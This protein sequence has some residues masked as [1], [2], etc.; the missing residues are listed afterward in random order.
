MKNFGEFFNNQIEH[1]GTIILSR[2]QNVSEDKLK[3]AI[4]M[5]RSLNADAHIITTPWDSL[6]GKQILAA[7]ENVTNLELEML[8]EQA[9]KTHEE[10]EHE[11]HHHHDDEDHSHCDHEHG[12]CCHHHHHGDDDEEYGIGTFVYHSRRPFNQEKLQE[13]VNNWPKGVVRAKGILWFSDKDK[14]DY[15]YVFEQAGVQITATEN[16][17]WLAAFPKSEQKKYFKE[18]PDIEEHWDEKYGDRETKLVFIG[19]HMDKQNIIE[20]LDNC[21]DD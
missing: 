7:M 15:L 5:I 10:H 9:E 11:H 13:F 3:K 4:E 2:T 21:L 16:G 12:H 1:A 19:Q 8:A 18:Y 14:R 17:K 6:D 20:R